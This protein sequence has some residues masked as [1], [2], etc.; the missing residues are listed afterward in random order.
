MDTEESA[1]ILFEN[2]GHGS[3]LDPE[4]G[5]ISIPNKRARIA[6]TS[7]SAAKWLNSSEPYEIVKRNI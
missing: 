2:E 6:A 4:D 7:S 3:L 5:S 1:L